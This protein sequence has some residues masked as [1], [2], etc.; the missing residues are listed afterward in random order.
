M[1]LGRRSR[2]LELFLNEATPYLIGLPD[3]VE[4]VFRLGEGDAPAQ[5][6]IKKHKCRD[7]LVGG[8]M[9]KHRPL[10]ECL[11]HS[12][13][14]SEILCSRS[15]EIH[16]DV[17]I[18]HAKA[19]NDTPLVRKGVVR[20]WEGEIDDGSKP[21]LANDPKLFLCGLAGSAEFVT[22]GAETVNLRQ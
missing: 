14:R 1:M 15:F 7:A 17:D 10:I 22:N 6:S 2:T 12:T 9:N 4:V 16:R 5:Y 18:R 11:H 3:C 8:A 20:G 21:G 19:S 13:E